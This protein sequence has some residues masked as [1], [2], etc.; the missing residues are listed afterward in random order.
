MFMPIEPAYIEALKYEKDLFA[1]GYE[2]NIVM[3]S[4]TTLM[5]ILRTV[6]NL[7]AMERSTRE[8]R[9]LGNKAGDIYNQVCTVAE[10]LARLGNSLQAAN[11]H[12]NLTVKSL[13][14][15]QGLSGKVDRFADMSSKVTKS[16]PEIDALNS[17]LQTA[18]LQLTAEPVEAD[19]ELKIAAGEAREKAS[20]T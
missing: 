20:G 11:N 7:W 10:R 15:R 3:V 2:R 5:P 1:Y 17:D 19:V 13:T 14:G 4:H 18:D 9:E 16:M 6:S 8:A 12:F